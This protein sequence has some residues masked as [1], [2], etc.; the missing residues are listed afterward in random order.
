MWP[1]H[2]ATYVA[3]V[4]L[5]HHYRCL[6]KKQEEEAEDK[7]EEKEE[8]EEEKGE[9]EEEEEEEKQQLLAY[10]QNNFISFL[11]LGPESQGTNNKANLHCICCHVE[12]TLLTA[13]SV[14][15]SWLCCWS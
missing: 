3:A 8:E 14:L 9:E 6:K 7:E 13:L 11:I 10:L 1:Q 4:L 5:K 2:V 12:K 15:A